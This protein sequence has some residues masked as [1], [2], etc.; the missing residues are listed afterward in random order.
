MHPKR[1]CSVWD[2]ATPQLQ[3]ARHLAWVRCQF[4]VEADGLVADGAFFETERRIGLCAV[5]SLEESNLLLAVAHAR[6]SMLQWYRVWRRIIKTILLGRVLR[7]L[8]G[9]FA[10]R[11][12]ASCSAANSPC[13][14]MR[15]VSA[16]AMLQSG[17]TTHTWCCT[18][19]AP[20]PSLG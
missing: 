17:V 20:S 5:W 2:G 9:N 16:A 13:F 6:R 14:S 12:P 19:E 11:G 3:M 18:V 10:C 8:C 7:A 15:K 1:G 4:C